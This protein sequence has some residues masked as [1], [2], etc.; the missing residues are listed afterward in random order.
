[1]T[2]SVV[3]P[4]LLLLPVVTQGSAVTAPRYLDAQGIEVIHGRNVPS[5][6]K[7]TEAP[8][9]AP[10]VRGTKYE[11][12]SDGAPHDT[13]LQ[14][15]VA[16]QNARDRDRVGILQQELTVEMQEYQRAAKR[17]EEARRSKTGAEVLARIQEEANEHGKNIQALNAELRRAGAA[18]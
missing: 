3:L 16:E 9:P 18:R 2:G 7:Q 4:L 11:P 17:L 15:G 6:A 12:P 8:H 5:P 1:M 13:R 10:I 14:I